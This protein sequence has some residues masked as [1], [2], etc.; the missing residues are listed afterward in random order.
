M[1]YCNC[2]RGI[3]SELRFV[4][5]YTSNQAEKKEI[6]KEA[7]DRMHIFLLIA[8]AFNCDLS[9]KEGNQVFFMQSMAKLPVIVEL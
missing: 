4:A 8:T 6:K 9:M 2:I 1:L 3:C 5:H 7:V